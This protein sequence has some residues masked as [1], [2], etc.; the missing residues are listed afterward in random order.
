MSRQ[1]QRYSDNERVNHW[2][3]AIS[4]VLAAL[5]GLAVFHPSMYWLSN[6]FGGGPWTRILHPFIGVVM[7]LFFCVTM[8]RFWGHNRLDANDKK[9][10]RQ[11]RDVI[12]N[13]E[14][15]LPESG[16]Y[17]AGQKAMF[18]LMVTCMIVLLVTGIMFW[19]SLFGDLFPVGL[20]RLASLLH[21]V[22]A[23]VLII[24]IIV[25]IYAAIW[26]KGSIDAMMRGTVSEAWAK[27][28]HAAW[29]RQV[30]R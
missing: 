30:I 25:H 26:T 29:Y 10:L 17:N 11:W 9:W 24:G 6:F 8:V 14:D 7:F 15:K 12:A 4:F 21:A 28:H 5:S 1:I 16:R 20:I 27:K 23:T 22:A 13:R 18:W 3:V 19:R 2:I